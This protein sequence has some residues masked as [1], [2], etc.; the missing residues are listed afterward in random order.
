MSSRTRVIS[1]QQSRTMAPRKRSEKRRGFPPNLYETDGYYSYRNPSTGQHFGLGRDKRHA[2]E[3]AIK[4]NIHL[5]GEASR[6][7]LV[8]RMSG[9]ESR[10]WSAWCDEFE[11]LLH[12]RQAKPN[13]IRTRKSQLKRLRATFKADRPAADIKTLDISTAL[14]TIKEE[15]KKRTAQAFRSFLIDCFDRMIASGWRADNPARVTDEITVKVKRARLQFEVFMR[16]YDSENTIWAK[17]AYAL[18][19]VSG[20]AREDCSEAMF[21]DIRDGAWWN[22]RGKT[23]ARICLPIELR[24]DRFGL[25][26]EDVIRQCRSTGVLSHYLIHQTENYGNSPAGSQIW[27]DTISKHF[28]ATLAALGIDW[29][30]KKPPTFHEI[31]S[32]SGRLYKTEGKVNPQELYGHK[33]PRTTAIYTDERGEWVRVSMRK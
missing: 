21:K 6:P 9:P 12:E 14:K 29:G 31:R 8:E 19:L 4:A 25:S 13:T 27:V 16:V 11:K 23:G 18:A 10:T 17:N 28:S 22:E 7:S 32:L 2:F 20:Q 1:I 30:D 33:D 3:E 26:L 5:A 24:I 15:G